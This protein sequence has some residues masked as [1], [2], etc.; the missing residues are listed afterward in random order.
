MKGELAPQTLAEAYEPGRCHLP[1]KRNNYLRFEVF[2]AIT[3]KNAVFTDVT[4]R[5]SC[6]N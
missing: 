2:T 1:E 5:G 4:P 3:M 6:N